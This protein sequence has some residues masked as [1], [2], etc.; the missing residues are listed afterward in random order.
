MKKQTN[1]NC[2][3]EST[4]FVAWNVRNADGTYIYVNNF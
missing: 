1:M 4:D 3:I 2:I